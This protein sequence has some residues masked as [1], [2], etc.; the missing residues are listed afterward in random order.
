MKKYIL[1]LIIIL[2]S[3]NIFAE[4]VV[5]IYHSDYWEKDFD[6][7]ATEIENGK[8]SVYIQ[9][10]AKNDHTRAMLEFESSDIEQLK[11]TLLQVRDKFAEWS[12]IAHD[13]NVTDM[14]KE[15]EFKLPLST[16]CWHGSKWF[17]SFR[18]KLQ[19][20]FSILD[21]GKHVVSFVRKA[22]ASSN[23]YIDETIYWVFA[24]PQDIDEFISVLNVDKIKEQLLSKEKA[25]DLF[26]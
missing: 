8:F 9:V 16:I 24:S 19:P 21:D 23:Q 12:K 17:F 10:P 25:A 3:T 20:Q 15:M 22:T 26:K 11:A 1:S 5:A 6:I 14:N 4:K 7:E 2:F 18:H 13:N